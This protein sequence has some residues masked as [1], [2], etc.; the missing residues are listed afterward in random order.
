MQNPLVVGVPNRRGDAAKEREGAGGRERGVPGDEGGEGGAGDVLHHEGEDALHLA[1][2]EDAHDAGMVQPG[3]CLRLHPKAVDEFGIACQV[4]R[5]HLHGYGF[6]E[7][8]VGA[9]VDG[10]H[11]AAPDDGIEPVA[12]HDVAGGREGHGSR[13]EGMR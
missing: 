11:S 2:G 4:G 13:R 1:E 9:P 8:Q 10:S 6:V 3:E 7:R 12:V 5:H